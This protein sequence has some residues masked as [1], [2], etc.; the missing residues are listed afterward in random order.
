MLASTL[1]L[2]PNG[3]GVDD[4]TSVTFTLDQPVPVRVDVLQA[5]T[6][7]A[8]IFQG[9]LGTGPQ[10]VTWNGTTNGAPLAEGVYELAFTVT[11]ALGDVRQTLPVTIDVTPPV[12]TVVDAKRLLFTLSEPATVTLLVNGQTRVVV[13]EPAGT[14]GVPFA[15]QVAGVVAQAQDFAGNVSPTVSG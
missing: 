11:D 2:S 8:T 5:G 1:A 4:S 10:T 13:G 14:F 3:D 12:L 7:I 15:G 9:T 6:V